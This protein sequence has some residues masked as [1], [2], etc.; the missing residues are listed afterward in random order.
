DDG[1]G[2]RPAGAWRERRQ[3]EAWRLHQ[4]AW[5]AYERLLRQ[6]ARHGHEVGA[7]SQLEWLR[8]YLRRPRSQD[9]RRQVDGDPRRFD[10]RFSLATARPGRGLWK[11]RREREIRERLRRGVEQS[12][13]RGSLRTRGLES[14]QKMAETHP[15]L[16][17]IFCDSGWGFSFRSSF[18]L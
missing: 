9:E 18:N 14:P 12:D 1:S 5:H 4:E 2:W 6:P 11:L 17:R 13:E 15:I 16:N 10:L 8:G 3:F 7:F